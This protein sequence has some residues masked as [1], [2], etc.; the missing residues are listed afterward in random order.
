LQKSRCKDLPRLTF[1]RCHLPCIWCAETGAYSQKIPSCHRPLHC[2][3][4]APL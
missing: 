1:A 3:L 4:F 2:Y